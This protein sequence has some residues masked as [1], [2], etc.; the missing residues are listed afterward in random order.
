MVTDPAERSTSIGKRLR[1][2]RQRSG[3]T[4]EGLAEESGCGLA[5]IRRIEQGDMEPR[6]ETARRLARALTVRAGWLMFGELP[7]DVEPRE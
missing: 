5:T 1:A 4:Q 3:L 6:A 2:A 7:M